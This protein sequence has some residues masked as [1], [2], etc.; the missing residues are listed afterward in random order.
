VS[1]LF[2]STL[3]IALVAAA[4]TGGI[5]DATLGSP[6]DVRLAGR[7]LRRP[8][9]LALDLNGVVKALAVDEAAGLI[10][11]EGFVS[12]GGDIAVR[13]PG[14]RRPARRRSSQRRRRRSRDERRLITRPSSNRPGH[15]R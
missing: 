4:D 15:P 9:G 12:A 6:G 2:A 7:L 3:E 10:S 1:P 11:E 8:P 14:R 5:V 13:G